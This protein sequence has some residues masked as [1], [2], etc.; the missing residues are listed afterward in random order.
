[1]AIESTVCRSSLINFRY[2]TSL[3]QAGDEQKMFVLSNR[4]VQQE[5][6]VKR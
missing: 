3:H 6:V 5:R 4:L 2:V 1:M